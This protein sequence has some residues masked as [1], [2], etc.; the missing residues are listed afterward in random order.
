MIVDYIKDVVIKQLEKI[1]KK[2][3]AE[4]EKLAAEIKDFGLDVTISLLDFIGQD[5][6]AIDIDIKRRDKRLLKLNKRYLESEDKPAKLLQA[7]NDEFTSYNSY[8]EKTFAIQ[9]T[10]ISKTID[11]AGVKVAEIREKSENSKDDIK[12]LE[13]AK[14]KTIK[15]VKRLT[16]LVNTKVMTESYLKTSKKAGSLPV[17]DQI[18]T[19]LGNN[20]SSMKETIQELNDFAAAV[21]LAQ[22]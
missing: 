21:E 22:G 9:K 14:K 10:K 19:D 1:F 13:S 6:T 20:I 17:D 15:T 12:A 4:V 3:K 7:L 5:L 2:F 18:L 8:V 16:E 11:A